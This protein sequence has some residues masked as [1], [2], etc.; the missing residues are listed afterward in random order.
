VVGTPLYLSPEILAGEEPTPEQD[1]WALHIVLWEVLAGH[2]PLHGLKIDAALDRL[3]AGAIPS[4][5]TAC[6]D[7][8]E[9]LATIL[10]RG[11][12]RRRLTRRSSAELLECDLTAALASLRSS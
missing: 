10:D 2:H 8:P 5:R 11:L 6:P 1:L 12:S 9:P 7:C 3:Q 4:I